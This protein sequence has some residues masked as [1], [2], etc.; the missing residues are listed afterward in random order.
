MYIY[1]QSTFTLASNKGLIDLLRKSGLERQ[2]SSYT[3]GINAI[4]NVLI[5]KN[6][7]SPDG[8]NTNNFKSPYSST[9]PYLVGQNI[10]DNKLI[11]G[12]GSVFYLSQTTVSSTGTPG[13]LGTY[14]SPGDGP[15]GYFETE[16]GSPYYQVQYQI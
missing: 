14:F 2:P 3:V 7:L 6:N 11:D 12:V 13:A 15:T 4:D 10:L 9:D 1:T 16:D 8:R 5:G